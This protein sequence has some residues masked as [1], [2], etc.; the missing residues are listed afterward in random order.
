MSSSPLLAL[1]A[2]AVGASVGS[3]VNL[4]ADRLP[5]G[6][7]LVAPPSSCDACG[8]RLGPVDLV[9]VLSYLALRGRCRS[10]GAPI[11]RRVVAVEAGLGAL[12]AFLVLRYG[13]TPLAFALA[14][15]AAYLAVVAVVDLEHLIIPDALVAAGLALALPLAPLWPLMGEARPFLGLTGPLGSL[16]GSAAAGAGAGAFLLA[17]FLLYPRGMGGG[18]V[19]LAVP[20]GLLTGVPGVL[21]MMGTAVLANGLAAA[22]LLA[23]RRRG[24]K[25]AIPFGPSLCLGT[26]VALLFGEEVVS[27]YLG[28]AGLL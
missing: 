15:V 4:A 16:A 6:R 11:P 25:D 19:L 18:D 26:L 23:T 17:V 10:C 12:Y 24:R 7:S 22:L 5:A 3:F 28:W 9:P 27:A 20:L 1:F 2:F 21:V 14:A 8:V 13:A